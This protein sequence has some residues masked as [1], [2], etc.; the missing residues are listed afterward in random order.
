MILKNMFTKKSSS[1]FIKSNVKAIMF[2]VAFFAFMFSCANKNQQGKGL[3][4][5]E[6][7]FVSRFNNALLVKTANRSIDI[8]EVKVKSEDDIIVIDSSVVVPAVYDR[9][10]ST[11]Y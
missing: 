11:Q 9:L 10:L 7:A 4:D 8:R 2:S 6:K 3:T 1:N 5:E